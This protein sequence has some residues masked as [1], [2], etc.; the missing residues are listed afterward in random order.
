M[1]RP[2][3]VRPP[4][5]VWSPHAD[6][7]ELVLTDTAPGEL[8]AEF[9]A[10]LRGGESVRWP[11]ATS[12]EL[13]PDDDGWWTPAAGTLATALQHLRPEHRTDP[14]YG[15]R[16]DGAGPFPDPRARRLPDT[17]HG[18]GRRDAAGR[19]ESPSAPAILST[20]AGAHPD[21]TLRHAVIYELHLGA[22]TT[23]GTLDA[24]SE[25]LEHLVELGVTH[26]E[27]MPVN[28]FSGDHNWGYD[29]VGWFAVD[30]SYGGP[31]A[32]RRFVAACHHRGLRVIQDVVYNHLGPDGNYLSVFGPYLSD[33]TTGWGDGPDL[34]GEH[35]HTVR[36][37]ILDNAALW[38]AEY[39]V[40]G[41][42]L[43]AV[44]ALIDDDAARDPGTPRLLEQLAVL[45][46]DITE[47]TGVTRHLIAESDLNDA[48][49]IT[50]RPDGDGLHAQWS[51]DY[52]HA[53]HAAVTGEHH[54]YYRDFAPLSALEKTLA[55]GFFH[56]GTYSSFRGRDHGVPLPA[57]TPNW[58]LVVS[59]QNHDQVGNRAAG[60][61]PSAVLDAGQLGIEAALLLL[62]PYTPMLFMGEEWGAS[63]PFAF[64]TAHRAPELAEAVSQGRRREFERM[65][66][67]SDAVLDPQ[68]PATFHRSRLDWTAAE[69]STLL[70]LYR[71]LIRLRAE[72]PALTAP[73]R[74]LTRA[75]VD[76]PSRYVMIDRWR[77]HDDAVPELSIL[78][79]LGEAP[80]PV[81][82]DLHS[83]AELVLAHGPE[84]FLE[85]LPVL[86][87]L[88]V[89]PPHAVAV[90]RRP[91]S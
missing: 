7:V 4:Y 27:L 89:L 32:Y 38:L 12:L 46:D 31:D 34:N 70:E 28:S 30:E 49:L 1:S 65:D 87:G 52:H 33:A 48:R 3:A 69:G 44:H 41:L 10:R 86:S 23:E 61:R 88:T 90:F 39:G 24:V 80:M 55:H 21:P 25:R 85:E 82:P 11:E 26:V 59:V 15:Y 56:N 9:T 54:G 47:R 20:S 71:R 67:D 43:D 91:L 19:T 8:H 78:L 60:D 77:R 18:P 84:G 83:E 14:G 40:D 81:P 13:V 58:R 62:G 66:W 50:P 45:A 6:R 37:F 76:E 63:T 57:D 16:I 29:G 17:V 74:T 68:D 75:A 36:E 72:I 22:F 5:A 42:R 64:F 35:G 79:T 51:D 53:V 73:D 2:A